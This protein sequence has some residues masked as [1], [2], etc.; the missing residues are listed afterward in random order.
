MFSAPLTSSILYQATIKCNDIKYKQKDANRKKSINLIKSKNGTTLSIEYLT[1]KEKNV[2]RPTLEIK[3]QCKAY[4]P[5]VKKFNP[6][7]NEKSAIIDDLDGHLLNKR[8]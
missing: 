1:L 6:C 7:L 2:L 8:S 5:T 4:Q 3:G